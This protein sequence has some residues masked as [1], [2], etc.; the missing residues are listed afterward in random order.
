MQMLLD[1]DE[2]RGPPSKFENP[3]PGGPYKFEIVDISA[4]PTKKGDK[5]QITINTH[6]RQMDDSPYIDNWKIFA[7]I[8]SPNNGEVYFGKKKVADI[9]KAAKLDV[10]KDSVNLLV[11]K[12]FTA[13]VILDGTFI[14]LEN[15]AGTDEIPF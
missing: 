3:A 4:G 9:M 6:I 12:F 1:F 10:K 15:I 5:E 7:T 14:R 11:G 13:Y 8:K 2:E